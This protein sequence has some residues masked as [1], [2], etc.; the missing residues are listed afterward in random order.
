MI[1]AD[2]LSPQDVV[3]ELRVSSQRDLLNELSRRAALRLNCAAEELSLALQARENL[4]STGLGNGV[5]IPHARFPFIQEPFGMLAR[6][7]QPIE[8]NAIDGLRADLFFLLLL[9]ASEDNKQLGAL[10]LV[11]RKLRSPVTLS[12]MRGAKTA[13]E[14][15]AAMSSQAA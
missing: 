12:L 10:A 5:A 7:K 11:A 3:A 1:I 2:I 6:L 13:D 8:F 14:L 15:Y 4:G 9:P